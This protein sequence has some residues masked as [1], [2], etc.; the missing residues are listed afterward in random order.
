MVWYLVDGSQIEALRAAA[1]EMLP[2]AGVDYHSPPSTD[3]LI[4]QGYKIVNAEY[5]IDPGLIRQYQDAG[6]WVNLYT[7]DEPW[8]FSRLWLLG[9]DSITTSNAGV[10]AELTRPFLSMSFSLYLALW[11]LVGLI[12]AGLIVGLVYPVVH[13]RPVIRSSPPGEEI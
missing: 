11:I 7:V 1:P 3:E 9:A 2:A 13:P 12:G 8:Q 4:N 5:G 10:M 6:L